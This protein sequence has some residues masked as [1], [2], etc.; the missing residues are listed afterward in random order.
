MDDHVLF[1][2]FLV[3]LYRELIVYF[4]CDIYAGLTVASICYLQFFPPPYDI[5]GTCSLSSVSLFTV[6]QLGINKNKE[7]ASSLV[8]I[9]NGRAL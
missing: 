3:A 1:S 8:K 2:S 5:D 4:L 7:L 6:I 9:L